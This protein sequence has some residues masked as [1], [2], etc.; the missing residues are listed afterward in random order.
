MGSTTFKI[1][2]HNFRLT[3]SRRFGG[4]ERFLKASVGV[5]QGAPVIEFD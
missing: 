1:R 5:E 2:M 3:F 4:I